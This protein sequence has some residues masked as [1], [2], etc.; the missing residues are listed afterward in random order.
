MFLET[1]PSC[2]TLSIQ[3]LESNWLISI[4]GREK[5]LQ[6]IEFDEVSI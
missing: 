1:C 6:A 2:E 4:L 5:L 3:V